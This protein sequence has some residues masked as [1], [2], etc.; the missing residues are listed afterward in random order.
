MTT[1]RLTRNK[2]HNWYKENG[3]YAKGYFFT[4]DG[5]LYRDAGLCTYFSK[6]VDEDDFRQKLL[7]A[8][9][10]F[11]VIIQQDTKLWMAVDRLR[12]FPLFYRQK[13][14]DLWI[15]DEVNSLFDAGEQKETDPDACSEFSGLSYVLGNKTLL[16]TVFQ[17]QAGEMIRYEETQHRIVPA[18]YHRYF[19]E[20]KEISFDEAKMQLKKIFQNIGQ[21][22]VQLIGDRPVVVSLSG[23]LDS[24]LIAFLLKK[25]GIKK[26]LC[27]TFGIKKGNPEWER[28]KIVAEK[29]GFQWL[30]ID[31]GTMNEPDFRKQKRFINMVDY[32]AQYVSKFGFMQYFATNYLIDEVKIPSDSIW[33]VGNGGDFFSGSHLRPYMQKYKSISV[34]A[35]DLQ[36]IHG[37]LVQ[38]NRKER[39]KIRQ[40]IQ[41]ELQTTI[42]LFYN[43]E[44]WDLKERQ[45]KYIFN[46]DKLWEY[47]GIETQIPLCDTELMDFFVSLPFEYRLN[48]KLYKTVL[49]ELFQEYDIN[50][51]QDIQM[52]EPTL[53]QQCK[54]WI[55]R[56]F[57]FLRKKNNL[58]QDDYF[59][60]K[61]FSQSILKELQE[62]NQAKKIISSNGIFSEWYLMQVKKEVSNT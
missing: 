15:S 11:S 1:I 51:T 54:I 44:N 61:R 22:M 24:R 53:I 18:F 37:N 3:V 26:V 31:Y 8:N 60:F 32:V 55:K 62:K 57:P 36:Y 27:Y 46:S 5:K 41:K 58:F 7:T 49:T 39:E 16:K 35:Q 59:D 25:A 45:A 30:F 47:Y 28:S 2:V 38:L 10:I 20:I 52:K 13:G 6:L 9:G 29:L 23:G 34:I 19:S 40:T 33:F 12:Y 17:L 14:V 43:V 4:P 48:Q 56:A 42:P 21:R 50:F